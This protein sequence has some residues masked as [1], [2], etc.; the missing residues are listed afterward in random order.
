M[1]RQTTVTSLLD[2]GQTK[3][4]NEMKHETA[5]VKVL[6]TRDGPNLSSVKHLYC[7]LETY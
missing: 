6:R 3:D 4:V 1:S 2:R 5:G 7:G